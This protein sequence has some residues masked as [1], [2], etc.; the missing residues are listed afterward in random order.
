MVPALPWEAVGGGCWGWC[1]SGEP[2][3]THGDQRTLRRL[4]WGSRLV[5]HP[6]HFWGYVGLI[7]HRREVTVVPPWAGTALP[8]DSVVTCGDQTEP[9]DRA[10]AGRALRGVPITPLALAEG[11]TQ[12]GALG[13]HDRK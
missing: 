12:P 3:A 7:S 4:F 5:F 1:W 2:P 13:A 10:Q 11:V 6:W 9:G 8:D